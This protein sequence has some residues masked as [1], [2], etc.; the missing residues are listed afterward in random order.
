[1]ADA[2]EKQDS[3]FVGLYIA[4][5][6]SNGVLPAN[7]VFK[8]REPNEFD[9]LGGDYT[10]VARR[11]YSPSRQRKKGGITDLDADGGWNEDVTL[12]NMQSEMEAFF[13]AA[14]R[15][16]GYSVNVAAVAST[17]DFTVD[18]TADFFTGDIIL[19][20]GFANVGN[21][22]RHVI[23]SITDGTHLSTADQL[24]DEAAEPGQTV[25]RIGHQYVAGDLSISMIG[26]IAR[27]V[28]ATNAFLNSQLLAGEY[29]VVGD[30]GAATQ[31]ADMPPFYARV[32]SVA[33]NG[34]YIDLDK[35]TRTITTNNG[36]GKTIR[37]FW[38]YFVKNEYDPDL[39]VKYTH[40]L[41]RT[42]GRDAD[43]RQSEY[44]PGFT[45]NELTWNSPLADKVSV[46]MSG[47][48]MKSKR[49]KGAEGPLIAQNGT[50]VLPAPSEDFINT[51]SNVYRI[52]LSIVDPNTLN[53]TPLFAR[54]TEFSVTVNNNLS[55]NKAQGTLGAFDTT[56]GNFD[57]DAEMTAYF[58]TVDAVDAIENNE[59]CTFDVIYTK[60]NSAIILDIPLIAPGGGR[61]TIEMDQPIM[62]PMSIAAAESPFGHTAL[63]NWL[64]YVPDSL[65]ATG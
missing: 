32:K 53:P 4:R 46:D 26:G 40:T 34:A 36:A 64:P 63:L 9:D 12:H 10:L 56:A 52:R 35:T 58:S 48:G 15:R 29:I 28:S 20:S 6:A 25:E 2:P 44:I 5:E 45:Y 7:P 18:A 3:N 14:L 55:A 41:E 17:D 33:A 54:V 57:V 23:D 65:M 24:T 61:L 51:S 37:I 8:T 62:L 47:I 19:A 30:T 60:D 59:D 22:G 39:I 1:M 27:I 31:F 11:P 49:R 43:G 16:K 50:V 13:F 21:N 42:L 38:G